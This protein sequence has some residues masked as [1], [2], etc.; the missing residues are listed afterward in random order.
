MSVS[1]VPEHVHRRDWLLPRKLGTSWGRLRRLA[2]AAGAAAAAAGRAAVTPHKAS[3]RRL[4]DM[5]LTVL[6]TA[7]IDFGAFHYVHL[8]G[9]LVTGIS[10][11]VIEHLI[12]DPETPGST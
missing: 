11:I 3:L 8:V 1:V 12:A 5:P 4:A 2:G 10:L 6:G 9:W 7:A